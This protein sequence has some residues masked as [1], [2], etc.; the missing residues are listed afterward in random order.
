MLIDFQISFTASLSSKRL[1]KH[2]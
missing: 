2:Y 1:M